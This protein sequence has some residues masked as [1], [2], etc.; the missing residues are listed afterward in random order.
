MDQ[1]NY[2]KDMAQVWA[3]KEALSWKEKGGG[4]IGIQCSSIPEE[5]V[6]AAGLLPMKLRTAGLANTKNADA[7]LHR[8]N[9]SFTRSVLEALIN[10]QLDILDGMVVAN[11]CDHHL[12]LASEIEDKSS[13]KFLH[14]FRVN[15]T[16]GP[17]GKE[18]LI[19]EMRKLAEGLERTFDVSIS[20][21]NLRTAILV[22]NRTRS[23]IKNLNEMRKQEPPLL[24]GTEFMNIALTGMSVP[25]EPFNQML[26]SLTPELKKRVIPDSHFPRLLLLGGAC[27][28]PEFVE[29]IEGRGARVV[30]D[31]LCFGYR[32]LSGFI[33]ETA[34]DPLAAIADRYLNRLPCPAA[35]D[36]TEQT[37]RILKTI[38]E[39]NRVEGVVWARLKFCDHY[40]G[41]RKILSDRL[42][43]DHGLPVIEL[44]REYSTAKSGQLSTRIQAFLELL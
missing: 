23:L 31:G 4:V 34:E 40:S 3:N 32:H 42:R 33:D 9:C 41:E 44:E 29:F 37:Y 39:E 28:S 24:T 36:G 26:E 43:K 22:Y 10:G 17:G 27:D 38:I 2:F 14:Y 12:R 15:H 18:W 13:M 1:L 20:D 11:T 7:H 19:Q 8:I 6:F 25:R 16:L 21:K 35:P 5:L 30:A